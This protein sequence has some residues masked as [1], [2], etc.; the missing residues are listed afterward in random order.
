[1]ILCEIEN[2]GRN[3]LKDVVEQMEETDLLVV[4]FQEDEGKNGE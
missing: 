1:M 4:E 2:V 3:D